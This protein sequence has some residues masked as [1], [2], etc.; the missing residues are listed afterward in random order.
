MKC[1]KCAAPMEKV[2]YR[3]VE[4]DR[5]TGCQGLWLD[6]MEREYLVELHGS[7]A[8]DTGSEATGEK[9]NALRDIDCPVCNVPMAPAHDSHQPHIQF[10]QCPRCHG[11]FLDAGELRDLKTHTFGDAIRNFLLKL[12]RH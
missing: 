10:E 8:I 1:P 2:H 9:S 7:Q 12:R 6:H 5:C 3:S 11:V 4:A